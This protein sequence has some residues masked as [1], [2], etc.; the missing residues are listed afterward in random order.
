MGKKIDWGELG[1]GGRDVDGFLEGLFFCLNIC[2][3]C[4]FFLLVSLVCFWMQFARIIS[5]QRTTKPTFP[6]RQQVEEMA[7]CL[8]LCDMGL[9][10]LTEMQIRCQSLA[11]QCETLE[12]LGQVIFFGACKR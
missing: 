5:T 6:P 1:V 3:F 10:E 7:E 12:N 4:V 9:E 11:E 2:C 8:V